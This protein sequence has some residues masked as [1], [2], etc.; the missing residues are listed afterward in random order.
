M[1]P[2]ANSSKKQVDAEIFNNFL[3]L[4]MRMIVKL[5]MIHIFLLPVFSRMR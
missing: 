3:I 5:F 2:Q 1:N 4:L